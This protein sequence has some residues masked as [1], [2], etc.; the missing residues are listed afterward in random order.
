VRTGQGWKIMPG[1]FARVG[2]GTDT[3]AIAMQKGGHAA[4]VWIVGAEPVE[5]RSLLPAED[6]TAGAKLAAV[7]PSRA[8][9][10]LYWL[11]RYI[12]RAD[13]LARVLRAY[14][15][16]VAE[17]PDPRNPVIGTRLVREWGGIEHTVTVMQDGFDWQGRRFKSLSATARA[18]TGS[19]WNGYRFF[20]LREARKGDR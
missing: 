17:S 6:D 9:D 12:E 13:S 2:A 14:N 4:D 10:N 5:H 16:R 19:N 20:G 18:I 7:L 8:A 15:G 11:G 3:M 1:G